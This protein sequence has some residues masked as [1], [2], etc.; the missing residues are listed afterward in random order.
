MLS[1]TQSTPLTTLNLSSALGLVDNS[2]DSMEQL[3]RGLMSA[4]PP[5]LVTA[6]VQR[7]VPP[8][9]RQAASTT[10]LKARVYDKQLLLSVRK[11]MTDLATVPQELVGL[12]CKQAA[13]RVRA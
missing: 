6:P 9:V 3:L 10:N 2:G 8:P 12:S 4:P 13:V 11:Q 5:G 1:S 7:S